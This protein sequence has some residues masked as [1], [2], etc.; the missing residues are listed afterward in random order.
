MCSGRAATPAAASAP[1]CA[2]A[3]PH[4]GGD[5]DVARGEVAAAVADVVAVADGAGTTTARVALLDVLDRDDGVGAL[6]DDAARR[7]RHRLA[8]PRARVDRPAGGDRARRSGASPGA[9]AG[10]QRE[11]VHRRG[12]KRRQVDGRARVLGEHAAGGV[13]ERDVLRPRAASTRSRTSASASSI[14]SSSAHAVASARRSEP[15]LAAGP[16]PRA[17]A[18]SAP[19][20]GSTGR[21]RLRRLS[22]RCVGG[23]S[24][25][26]SRW[27]ACRS[28]HGR[29]VRVAVVAAYEATCRSARG[30]ARG[31]AAPAC[32][33]L[34]G[35]HV[36]VP[37]RHRESR[38]RNCLPV[39]GEHRD[40][41]AAGSPSRPPSRDRAC[42][43]RTRR[44]RDPRS[45]PSCLRSDGRR[46]PSPR[47]SRRARSAPSTWLTFQAT[48]SD[49]ARFVCGLPQ[50]AVLSTLPPGRID[51]RGSPSAWR[52]CRR[53]E[54]RVRGRHLERRDRQRAEPD[55]G[56]RLLRQVDPEPLR[57]P[58]DV[59]GADVERELRVDGVVGAQ[60]RV[61]DRDRAG[62]AVVV[63]RHVPRLAGLVVV[64]APGA[65]RAGERRRG[66]VGRVGVDALLDRRG[67][68]E[69]LE[70]RAGLARRLGGEV[71]LVRSCCRGSP[72][73]S[74]GSRRCRARPRRSRPPGRRAGSACR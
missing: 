35:R 57:H 9:S 73:S 29:D 55:R 58:P 17:A 62:V 24:W 41:A 26:S 70:R 5:D 64:L 38:A 39:H 10:A 52:R 43:R 8:R 32:F 25:S 31:T 72:R 50:P 14:V 33:A 12:R 69:R 13:L 40:L 74:R 44:R 27:S 59:V 4:A 2:G 36:G 49:S 6:R 1:T 46:P 34:G 22:A 66:V 15:G 18:R 61:R 30:S 60:R 65:G 51:L 21:R 67:E 47:P 53:G 71:E 19:G 42:S 63:G 48:P 11:A 54:R 3:E 7:D 45:S 56:D 68:H 23:R 16:R 20:L 37:D 28:R